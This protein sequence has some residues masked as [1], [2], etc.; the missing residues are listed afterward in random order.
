LIFIDSSYL[1]ALVNDNDQW[2]DKAVKIIDK[3]EKRKTITSTLNISE[4]ITMIG[5][6]SGGKIADETFDYIKDNFTITDVTINL[7]NKTR[8]TYL[9]Y[10]G[11][12]S[13]ADCVAV[14]IMKKYGISEI[15]SFDSDFDKV[16]GIVRIY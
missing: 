12:L 9:K 11:T 3:I 7:L 10:D 13:L 4:T 5:K 1:I 14:L 8:K 2:H 16:K 15:V 6:I